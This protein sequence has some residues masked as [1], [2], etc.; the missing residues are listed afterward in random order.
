MIASPHPT[1]G[2]K[3]VAG[4]QLIIQM[5]SLPSEVSLTRRAMYLVTEVQGVMFSAYIGLGGCVVVAACRIYRLKAHGSTKMSTHLIHTRVAAQ[6][7]AVGA[8][9]LGEQLVG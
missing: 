6:A 1:A 9:M 2:P 4:R 8:I 3:A 5:P 7:C